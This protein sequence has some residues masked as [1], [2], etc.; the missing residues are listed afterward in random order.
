L[1]NRLSRIVDRARVLEGAV[2][3]ADAPHA[4]AMRV[5]LSLP[6]APR[7]LDTLAISLCTI[8]ALLICVVIA[9]L[10]IS[11]HLAV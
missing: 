7:A 11:S 10:F 3:T 8:C 5:E 9:T 4:A 1:I 2:E 6:R